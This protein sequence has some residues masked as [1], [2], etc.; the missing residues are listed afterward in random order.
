MLHRHHDCRAAK[1]AVAGGK[2]FRIRGTHRR[3]ISAHTV[4]IH[5]AGSIQCFVGTFLPHRSNHHSAGNLESTPLN[6][7][8]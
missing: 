1:G 7:H 5:Q 3:K 4:D 6:N 8:G 2:N